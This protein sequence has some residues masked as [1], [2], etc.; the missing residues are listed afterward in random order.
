MAISRGGTGQTTAT[1]AFNALDPLTTKGDVLVNNGTNSV[2]LPVGTNNQVLTA[3]SAQASGVKWATPTGTA[4][5]AMNFFTNATIFDPADSTT[6]HFTVDGSPNSTA[7]HLHY[8]VPVTG[9]LTRFDL[10]VRIT[11]TLGSSE[12]V[13]AS[14]RLRDA[15]TACSFTLAY[16]VAEPNGSTTCSSSVTAGDFIEVRLVTPA[17]ATNPFDVTHR[18]TVLIEE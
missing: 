4:K 5:V 2:R 13:T 3:D 7:N 17:W 10:V 6:Y 11:S 9:N 18:A 12:L 14:V 8:R 16:N 1:S 15:V